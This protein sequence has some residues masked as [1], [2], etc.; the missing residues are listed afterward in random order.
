MPYDP[1]TTD[2]E[3]LL[4]IE[5]ESIKID[6][7]TN[8]KQW[9]VANSV[10]VKAKFAKI[11]RQRLEEKF[12]ERFGIKF[13]GTGEEEQQELKYDYID[14]WKSIEKR[15]LNFDEG[16]KYHPRILIGVRNILLFENAVSKIKDLEV[17]EPVA[18]LIS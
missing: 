4:N 13:P 5:S 7:N 3:H 14:I 1:Q 15:Y 6:E 8:L 10:Q 12:E 18:N 16:V 9:L 17:K 2:F 11:H